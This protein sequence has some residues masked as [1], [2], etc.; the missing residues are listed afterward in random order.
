MPPHCKPKNS[1]L[2]KKFS[3]DVDSLM[4]VYNNRELTCDKIKSEAYTDY[5]CYL[6]GFVRRYLRFIGKVLKY[7]GLDE[8]D[9]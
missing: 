5:Y 4:Q 6:W 7:K 8:N 3:D 9:R 1:E 2:L